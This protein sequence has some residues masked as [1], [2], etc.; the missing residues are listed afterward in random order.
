MADEPENL[1]PRMFRQIDAKLDIIM[2]RVHDLTAR[3]SSV[4]DQLVGLRPDFVHLEHRID[5]FDDRL[6]RFERRLDLAEA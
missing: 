3:M 1:T 2:D 5:R 4:E 6:L